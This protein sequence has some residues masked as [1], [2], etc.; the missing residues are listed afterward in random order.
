M[1]EMGSDGDNDIETETLGVGADIVPADRWFVHGADDEDVVTGWFIHDGT[2]LMP[3]NYYY[4]A[5]E[6]EN[7]EW[8]FDLF[9]QPG[10]TQSLLFYVNGRNNTNTYTGSGEDGSSFA[11]ARVDLLAMV[12]NPNVSGFD[13][14]ELGR[15]KN[16]TFEQSTSAVPEP[17]TM[18]LLGS[19]LVGMTLRRRRPNKEPSRIE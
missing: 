16:F 8:D 2:A 11:E 18:L 17:A 13:Y 14:D 4:G 5:E 19:G 10:E 6:D 12:A 7:I 9:L 3:S 15:V 1:H